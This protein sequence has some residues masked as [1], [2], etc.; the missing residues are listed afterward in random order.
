MKRIILVILTVVLILNV[1]TTFAD[2]EKY[3][4]SILFRGIPWGMSFTDAQQLFAKDGIQI[5]SFMG[6][7]YGS[8]RKIIEQDVLG[9]TDYNT[10]GVSW[11]Y[12][13]ELMVAGFDVKQVDVYFAYRPDENK[14]VD[15]KNYDNLAFMLAN[16]K[17]EP[18]DLQAATA[19]MKAK[20]EKLYGDVDLTSSDS[21]LITR[22]YNYWLASDN[23]FVCLEDE[24]Y[25]TTGTKAMYVWYGTLD[26]DEWMKESNQ[27]QYDFAL[28]EEAEKFGTDNT[29]GL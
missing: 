18:T 27:V 5:S 1:A 3:E 19:D 22:H 20:L 2:T 16:Y 17:F 7:T 24:E 6:S 12:P 21:F 4:G 25:T 11:A 29:D 10:Y 26:A 9:Y 28:K 8:I 13:K 15:P 14:L 23:S